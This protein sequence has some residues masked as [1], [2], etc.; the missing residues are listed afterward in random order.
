MITITTRFAMQQQADRWRAQGNTIALVPTMGALHQGHLALVERAK[1]EAD[2]VVVSIFVNPTQF[3]PGEDYDRYPRMPERDAELLRPLGVDVF[4]A[5]SA[6]ELYPFGI[7]EVYTEV[8][9][10]GLTDQLCGAHR[11]GH[12]LGVTTVVTKLLLACKPHIAVFG[13]KDAQQYFVLRRMVGELGFDVELIG[14]PTVREPDGLAMSSRNVYLLDGERAHASVIAKSID[15]TKDDIL[16]GELELGPLVR[17]LAQ[18]IA[19]AGGNVQYADVV[20]TR[21]LT[22]VGTA[23]PGQQLLIAVAAFFGT[24]RLIDNAIV[25]VPD[26]VV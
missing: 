3:A 17:R 21:T 24:T 20:E 13:L 15:R 1:A 4:F 2:M 11:E 12:F 8:R 6:G 16:A 25:T 23:T 5:P 7:D 9:V 22:P 10:K 26:T 14:V 19:G 18:Q